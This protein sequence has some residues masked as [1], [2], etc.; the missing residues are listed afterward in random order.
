MSLSVRSF[1]E[2]DADALGNVMHRSVQE[3]AAQRYNTAQ[4]NAWCPAPPEGARWSERLSGAETVVAEKDDAPVGFMAMDASGYLDLAFVLPEVMGHGV[5]DA[6]Y[7]VLEGRAR[8]QGVATLST[9]ASLLAEPFF[10]RRGWQV[11]RRQEVKMSGV[12]L[13]NAWMEKSLA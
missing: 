12:V 13:E 6:I 2:A 10:A 4:V 11:K 5:A 3:G 1:A 8:T 7:A 9:Q